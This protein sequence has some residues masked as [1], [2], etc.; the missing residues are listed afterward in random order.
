MRP[1]FEFEEVTPERLV[2]EFGTPLF[3]IS[4]RILRERLDRYRIAIQSEWSDTRCFY[5]LKANANPWIA[6]EAIAAGWGIDVCSAGDLAIAGQ[7]GAT[8]GLVSFA[9]VGADARLLASACDTAAYVNLQTPAQVACVKPT[10]ASIGLRIASAPSKSGFDYASSK[11]G[12]PAQAIPPAVDYLSANDIAVRGIHCHCG[13]SVQSAEALVSLLSES[14]LPVFAVLPKDVVEQL[15]YVNIGGG[16]GLTYDDAGTGLD[17]AEYAQSVSALMNELSG[18][19]G[20]RLELHCEPGEWVVG[21]SGALVMTV[22]GA[23]DGPEARV[24][25]VDASLNQFMGTSFFD[26]GNELESAVGS[27]AP[28]SAHD[29]FGATNSPADAFCRNKQ[30]PRVE[31][32]DTLVLHCTGA[33]GYVRGGRFNE[34]PQAAEAMVDGRRCALIRA[35][36]TIADLVSHVP[37]EAEWKDT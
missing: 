18:R 9:G 31:A 13:S 10:E 2:S 19:A 26:P 4:R 16:L 27:G 17:V 7:A 3:V 35:R 14:L 12:L 21:P 33:Y 8:R 11:F 32:G 34:H 22:V 5:S 23:F 20:H 1:L 28:M 15:R 37:A 6:R 29:V 36:E 24:A 30:L 25:I